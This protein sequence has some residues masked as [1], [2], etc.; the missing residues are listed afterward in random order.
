MIQYMERVSI[1]S[2]KKPVIYVSPHG[3]S[4]DDLNTAL[5]AEQLAELTNGYAVINRGWERADKIDYKMEK[6]NCNNVNH[7]HQD[8]IKE[9]F[10]DPLIRFKNRILK[11]WERVLIVYLHGMSNNILDL[12]GMSDLHYVVGW[13][14]GNPASFT[15]QKWIKD[16]II[17]HLSLGDSCTVGEGMS[18][19]N[20]AGWS[21]KN[22]TQ[23]FRKW[24]P[25][26]DVDSV[27]LEIINRL[28]NTKLLAETTAQV[29]AI[30]MEELLAANSQW[31]M[32]SDFRIVK[33]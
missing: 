10:L 23:L 5:I 22:M 7:C 1:I 28:R 2:G 15:C 6:A 25:N 33:V 21:R 27:Q 19:G 32:P 24:Y 12:V 17:Y 13:G 16:F 3:A 8:V 11:K 4:C 9:E 14:R 20:Y 26:D 30:T 29:I 18:G 31:M